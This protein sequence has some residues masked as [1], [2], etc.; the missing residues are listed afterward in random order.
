MMIRVSAPSY[1]NNYRGDYGE[2]WLATVAAGS[3]IL[4]GTGPT[5]DLIKADVQ[6]YLNGEYAGIAVP[7]VMVQVKTTINLAVLADGDYSYNLDVETYNVL[8]KTNQQTRRVLM[9]VGLSETGERVR[10]Q[11][12]GTLL[13]GRSAWVSLEGKPETKNKAEV[14]VHLPSANTVDRAGLMR[15]LRTYGV[16]RSSPVP[17][18]D[19]WSAP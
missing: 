17:E 9:V 14:A 18:V 12:N 1:E 10:L 6:L 5:L 2:A 15:M 3:G 16:R 7:S 11:T 13:V 4:H 8:R 19:P